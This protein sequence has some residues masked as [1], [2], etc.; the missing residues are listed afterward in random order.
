MFS[1]NISATAAFMK[2]DMKIK[3]DIVKAIA[4]EKVLNQ[5]RSKL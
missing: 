2:G 5:V 1:G 3:G 4:L